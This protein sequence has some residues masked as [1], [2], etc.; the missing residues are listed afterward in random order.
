MTL[1]DLASYELRSSAILFE[2]KALLEGPKGRD[3]TRKDTEKKAAL[4][5]CGTCPALIEAFFD[6]VRQGQGLARTMLL[7]NPAD[8]TA[9][10][11]LG[12]LDLNYVWLQLGPLGHRTGWDE[13]L[14]SQALARCGAQSQPAPRTRPRGSRLDG[15]YRRHQDAVGHALAVRRRKQ[16]TGPRI[17]STGA[18]D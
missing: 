11:F 7:K 3:E 14:G 6:D 8:E 4:K 5:A 9:L 2:L 12:K 15:L 13:Y 10:F 17:G 18:P 1:L 16:E